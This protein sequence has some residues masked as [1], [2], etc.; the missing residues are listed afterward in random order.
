MK[1]I[2]LL[3]IVVLMTSCMFTLTSCDGSGDDEPKF[4]CGCPG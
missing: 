1:K 2:I 3:A 4:Y